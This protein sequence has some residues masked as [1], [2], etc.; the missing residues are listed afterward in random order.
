MTTDIA[1][2][3]TRTITRGVWL[4]MFFVVIAVLATAAIMTAQRTDLITQF[5]LSAK[6]D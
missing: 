3:K 2:G 6:P 4:G 1:R 5:G